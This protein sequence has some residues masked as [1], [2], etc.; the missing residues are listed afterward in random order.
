MLDIRLENSELDETGDAL[1]CRHFENVLS[2]LTCPVHAQPLAAVHLLGK[3]PDAMELR[4]VGCCDVLQS[5][6]KKA[7][8]LAESKVTARKTDEWEIAAVSPLATSIAEIFSKRSVHGRP[9]DPPLHVSMIRQATNASDEE[10]MAAVAELESLRWAIARRVP[11]AEPFGYNM[12]VP[13]ERLFERI[14]KKVMGWDPVRDAARVAA[15]L[16]TGDQPGL[17]TRV[18]AERLAWEPRRLNPALGYLLMND[19]ALPR[20]N[21]DRIYVAGYVAA[22]ARTRSFARKA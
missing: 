5:A 4:F 22:N 12:V 6:A 17:E 9:H 16:V 14:D 1:I 13:T 10:L 11:G 18:L 15:E 7:L 20:G 2:G 8:G 3:W 21:V 19:L